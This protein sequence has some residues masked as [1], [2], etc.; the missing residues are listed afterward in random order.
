MKINTYRILYKF[1]I[2]YT[3]YKYIKYYIEKDN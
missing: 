2:Y 1:I 3:L